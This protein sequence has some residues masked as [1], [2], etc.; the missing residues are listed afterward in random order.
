MSKQKKPRS[1][2]YRP[3]VVRR[4]PILYDVISSPTKLDKDLTD[5]E[6][7]ALIALNQIEDGKGTEKQIATV[8]TVIDQAYVAAAAFEQK[9]EI[10]MLCLLATGAWMAAL[11]EINKG[12][13][14]HPCITRV[15]REAIRL[16]RE[17]SDQC[18]RSELVEIQRT[19]ER[20][21]R[22]IRVNPRDAFIIE[23]DSKDGEEELKDQLENCIG[24]TFINN[25]CRSG[26]LSFDRERSKW[27]WKMPL[28]GMQAV[29]TEPIFVLFVEENGGTKQ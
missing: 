22:E 1:K 25:R 28:E 12:R 16:N 29:I 24:I 5:L 15:I 18:K 21:Y 4:S 9:D 6:M 23:P 2:R 7:Y 10:R 19:A 20:H 17:L 26:Y 13:K 3:K 11:S 27:L 14:P 8:A